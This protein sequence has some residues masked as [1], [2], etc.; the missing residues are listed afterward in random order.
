MSDSNANACLYKTEGEVGFI[1]VM[2]IASLSYIIVLGQII[3]MIPYIKPIVFVYE[4]M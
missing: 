4:V 1:D 3:V 2:W